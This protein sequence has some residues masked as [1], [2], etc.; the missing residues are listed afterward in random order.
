MIRIGVAGSGSGSNFQAILDAIEED[1]LPVEV[2]CVISDHA[3]AGILVKARRAGIPAHFVSPA[4]YRTKLDG[5][6]EQQA[7]RMFQEA[8]AECI[9][10]AGFMLMIKSGLLRAF[11]HRVLNIHPSLLPAFPGLEAWKQAVDYGAKVSGCTVHF[12]DEGMDTGPIIV[13]KAVPVLPG[14]T[15]GD[16]HTRILEQEHIA[17]PEA[18]RWLAE[19]QLTL[20]GRRVQTPG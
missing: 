11:P 16:L 7:I 20:D 13:Q 15:P 14:D 18:L 5:E 19:G 12:V 10:L 3:D 9:V 17:Y 1:G 8:G 6:A 4:P 2:A